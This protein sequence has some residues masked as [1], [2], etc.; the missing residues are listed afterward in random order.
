MSAA[1]VLR[2]AV[3]DVCWT[4]AL[5]GCPGTGSGS[6]PSGPAKARG[7]AEVRAP[8]EGLFRKG[9]GPCLQ[10]PGSLGGREP[11]SKGRGT[12]SPLQVD[13]ASLPHACGPLGPG[14]PPRAPEGLE[15]WPCTGGLREAW[16]TCRHAP[17]SPQGRGNRPDRT[18]VTQLGL[19]FVPA[20]PTS[21][22]RPRAQVSGLDGAPGNPEERQVWTK[23]KP[24]RQGTPMCPFHQSRE[25]GAPGFKELRE[26]AHRG[27]CG[28]RPIRG[29]GRSPSRNCIAK[30]RRRA[31]WNCV[32]THTAVHTSG[33]LFP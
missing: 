25:V 2:L 23:V 1:P 3:P 24:W 11:L 29:S 20:G 31:C 17:R 13:S 33:F 14:L 27:V 19:G 6:R 26:E 10:A 21:P 22:R 16:P 9:R 18:N 15:P 4:S 8:P 30:A 5:P 32:Y 7:G 28:V 12:P